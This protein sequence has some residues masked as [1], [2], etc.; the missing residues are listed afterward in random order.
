M[1]ACSEDPLPADQKAPEGTILDLISQRDDMDSLRKYLQLSKFSSNLSGTVG[2]TFFAPSNKAFRKL[3]ELPGMPSGIEE[4]NMEVLDQ[5]ISFH[6]LLNK[7]LR[8]DEMSGIITDNQNLNSGDILYMDDGKLGTGVSGHAVGLS[9]KNIKATNGYIHVIDE[10]IIPFSFHKI[11]MVRLG[12]ISGTIL[13][14]REYSYM[15]KL[16]AIADQGVI[17][18]EKIATLINTKPILSPGIT[19]FAV[20]ND[21]FFEIADREGITMDDLLSKFDQETAYFTLL[22]HILPVMFTREGGT[23]QYKFEDGQVIATV[24]GQAIEVKIPPSDVSQILIEAEYGSSADIVG[25]HRSMRNG[26]LF[27]VSEVLQP[28]S[29]QS[30]N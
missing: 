6:L 10:V 12:S 22:T 20:D 14:E 24:S 29:Y 2:R 17:L 1:I 25:A 28:F 26:V 27:K 9:E 11:Y 18:D 8:S 7:A 19:V 4:T 21:A 16:I 13:T 23:E 3:F 30:G 15:S 5:L